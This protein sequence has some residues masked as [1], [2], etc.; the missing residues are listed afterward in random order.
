MV[1]SIKGQSSRGMSSSVGVKP[2]SVLTE[3]ELAFKETGIYYYIRQKN[4]L[5]SS[6][7]KNKK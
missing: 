1:N 3:D 4:L 2:L 7:K 6:D 5:T